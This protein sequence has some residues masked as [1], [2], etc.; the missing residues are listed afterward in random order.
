MLK[1]LAKC[2]REYKDYNG[3]PEIIRAENW[4]EVVKL[5]H[6]EAECGDIVTLSPACASFDAFPNFA[7]R[8][9]FFKEE[10]GKL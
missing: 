10:V 6:K 1:Q 7:A 2:I 8:G 5:A 4:G 3:T 9:N